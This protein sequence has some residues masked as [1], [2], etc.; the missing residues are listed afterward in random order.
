[1]LDAVS[2]AANEW[3]FPELTV[4]QGLAPWQGVRWAAVNTPG[5]THA[6]D[7]TDTGEMASTP[8]PGFPAPRAVG[9]DLYTFA[10]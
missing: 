1:M 6:V 3:I 5:A 9:F 4:E 8:L 2:D 10:G 7:V